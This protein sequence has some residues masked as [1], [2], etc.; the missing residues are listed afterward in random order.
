MKWQPADTK[1]RNNYHQHLHHLEIDNESV[2]TK[3]NIICEF[4]YEQR[5][6]DIEKKTLNIKKYIS[7]G[8]ILSVEEI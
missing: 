4:E 3:Q 5:S 1:H 6:L 8:L 7:F 2:S